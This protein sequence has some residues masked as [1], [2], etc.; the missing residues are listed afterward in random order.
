MRSYE[1]SGV[2]EQIREMGGEVFGI[3]SEPQSLAEEAEE[4]W[5][6][7]FPIV[8]DPHHEFVNS[9]IRAGGSMF[10]LTLMMD[11]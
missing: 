6:L 4:A 11:T 5:D 8:G 3:T 9:F 7:S 10:S 2:V 1:K